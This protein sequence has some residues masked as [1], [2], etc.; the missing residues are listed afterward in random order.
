MLLTNTAID[1]KIKCVWSKFSSQNKMDTVTLEEIRNFAEIKGLIVKNVSETNFGC[2]VSIKGVLLETTLGSAILPREK[3]CAISQYINN[4]I[5]NKNHEDF[6][7]AVDWF[8]PPFIT[9][10][11][12]HE[13]YDESGINPKN[14]HII[15]EQDAQ[16]KFDSTLSSLYDFSNIIPIT[17]QTLSSSHAI[18]P[19]LP[20]I[21]EA[22]LA[23]YSGMQVASIAALIPIIERVLKEIIGQ[24]SE[25]L[26]TISSIKKCFDMACAGAVKLFINNTDWVPAEYYDIDFLKVVDERIRML[27]LIRYWLLNSFYAN[28]NKYNKT[29]GFNRHH[30]AHALSN[31]WQ[32]KTN[33]FRS[34]GL[35]QAMAF[36]ECF[37]SKD[38]KVSIFSPDPNE[39]S[40]SFRIEL[41]ACI[42]LQ[43]LKKSVL[44]KYQRTNE[45]PF[46]ITASDDGW[47]LRAGVLSEV[48]NDSV[49]LPLKNNGWQCKEFEDPVKDG[50]FI[51]IAAERGKENIKVALLYSCASS[52]DIYK[53]LSETCDFILFQG[54]AYYI[55][56][57]TKH[58]TTPVMPVNAWI[59]P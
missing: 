5:P 26:D 59:A 55:K 28:D 36:V 51:T 38:S 21:K 10:G 44:E 16:R 23:F 25:G 32:N 11:K 31:I 41:L 27:E 30:F 24:G 22:I 19:H 39:Q 46:N 40:E 29:S 45:L 47:L 37:A 33:F 42:H 48:M 57:F 54:P 7:K 14:F 53:E 35:L 17:I 18:A 8:A 43:V 56:D 3:P 6:W 4:I 13:I 50:E 49:I 2:F 34:L 58:I 9:N 52:R 15:D 1:F 20:I 12:L